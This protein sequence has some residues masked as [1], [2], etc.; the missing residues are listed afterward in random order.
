[1]NDTC[2]LVALI[3]I[4]TLR[5]VAVRLCSE[6]APSMRATMRPAVLETFKA[7]TFGEAY[8]GM[9]QMLKAPMWDWVRPLIAERDKPDP[10]VVGTEA[11]CNCRKG[12]A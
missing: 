9:Q 12:K 8:R 2:Y 5:V 4:A 11:T 3:D 10:V 6:A 1:M 7:A